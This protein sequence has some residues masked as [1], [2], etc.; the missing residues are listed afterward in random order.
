M[1]FSKTK[2][3]NK[4][5]KRIRMNITGTQSRP[6]LAVFRSNKEIYAQIV[7]DV[8]GKTLVAASSRDKDVTSAG[9]N[10]IEKA[11]LVGKALLKKRNKPELKPSLLTGAVI[12]ITVGSV[13][14]THLRAHE[15]KANLVCRLLLEK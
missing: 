1:A 13:S 8:E 5:K 11:T 15:T 6:R 7:D 12:Y 3:R 4:I 14:Y 2:R 9:G 10:K